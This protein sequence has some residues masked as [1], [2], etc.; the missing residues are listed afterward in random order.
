MTVSPVDLH[1]PHF[2]A[3]TTPVLRRAQIA[4]LAA[5]RCAAIR[6]PDFVPAAL[7]DEVLDALV[8]AEFDSYGEERVYPQVMRF[9]VGV[10]DHR[11]DGRVADGYWDAVESSRKAWAALDLS[12]DPFELCRARLGEHWPGA[13]AVGT[14]DGKEMGA[15]VAR[16]PNGGF[17]VHYDD[18][19]REFSGALLDAHLIAQFAFNLYLSVPESGGET[20]VWR[21][22]WSPADEQFRLPGSYGF[23]EAVVGSAESFELAPS[24]GEALLF[25]PRNFHAVR[26]SRGGRRIALGFSLGLTDTGE[27]LVWG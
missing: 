17:Q 11:E 20:V 23:G 12:F 26:P 3:V 7:C 22:R 10:S 1:D 15:G 24:P 2:F 8:G 13:V 5:G 6:V 9:G 21:H 18:A 25:D 27:I 16:E 19:S 14:R 4:D